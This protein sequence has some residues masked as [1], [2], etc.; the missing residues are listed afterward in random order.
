LSQVDLSGLSDAVI[1]TLT[2]QASESALQEC[3]LGLVPLSPVISTAQA[4]QIVQQI[5]AADMEKQTFRCKLDPET[6]TGLFST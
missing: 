3:L 1:T 6:L 5:D 2:T 4:E